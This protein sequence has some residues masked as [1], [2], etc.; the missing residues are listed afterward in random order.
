MEIKDQLD[1][2]GMEV[3]LDRQAEWNQIYNECWRQ[4]RDF[5]YA[6]NMHGVDW[7][8]PEGPVRA[9]CCPTSTTAPT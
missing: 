1:L 3:K 4:M 7:T 5:F 8:G 2:S 9:P 6:P